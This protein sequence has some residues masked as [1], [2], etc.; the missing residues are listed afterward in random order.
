LPDRRHRT[1]N[2]QTEESKFVLSKNL[3]AARRNDKGKANGISQTYLGEN[4]LGRRILNFGNI[5]AHGGSFAQR[6]CCYAGGGR[7]AP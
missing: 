4:K 3:N 6:F 2:L 5:D 7:D 1:T